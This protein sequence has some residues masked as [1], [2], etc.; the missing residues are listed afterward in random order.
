MASQFWEMAVQ[1]MRH[2]CRAF[3]CKTNRA[4]YESLN[5]EIEGGSNP[6]GGQKITVR[7]RCKTEVRY[8][9]SASASALAIGQGARSLR[10]HQQAEQGTRL[11]AGG[12]PGNAQPAQRYKALGN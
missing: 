2:H 6:L 3:F 9:I 11:P 10:A 5:C 1:E 4:N 8:Y 12:V 7:F